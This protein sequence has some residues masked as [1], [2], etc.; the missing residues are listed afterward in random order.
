MQIRNALSV[1]AVACC[2]TVMFG[3]CGGGASS[4]PAVSDPA[5]SCG[6]PPPTAHSQLWL[7]YPMP[8][9]TSVPSNVGTLVFADVN[10]LSPQDNIQLQSGNSVISG[11]FTAPPSPLPS[12]R[13]TPG[14]EFGSNTPYLALLV[15]T[16]SPTTTYTVNYLYV[17]WANNPPTCQ[18]TFTQTLGR[19]TTR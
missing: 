9:A 11:T 19:F 14:N 8:L 12:P 17:D 2:A 3:G 13:V 18:E 16:L 4:A 7:V 1:F 6:S 10:G 5:A 15:P